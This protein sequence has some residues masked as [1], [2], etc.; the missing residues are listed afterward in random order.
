MSSKNWIAIGWDS[1]DNEIDLDQYLRSNEFK[2]SVNMDIKRIILNDY[3]LPKTVKINRVK[4]LE[5]ISLPNSVIALDLRDTPKVKLDSIP[6]DIEL[7]ICNSKIYD[8]HYDK[9]NK[10]SENKVEIFITN[11]NLSDDIDSFPISIAWMK[12]KHKYNIYAKVI[13]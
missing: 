4:N 5:S 7:I 3:Y 1:N 12:I 10:L 8:V 2:I 13:E 6:A 9:F 11:T